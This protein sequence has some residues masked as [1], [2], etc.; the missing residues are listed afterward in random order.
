MFYTTIRTLY[1]PNYETKC[2]LRVILNRKLI[3][4][5]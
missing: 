1:A 2:I 4:N 5:M 3:E